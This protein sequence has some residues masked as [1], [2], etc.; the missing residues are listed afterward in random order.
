MQLFAGIF[1]SEAELLV[2]GEIGEVWQVLVDSIDG[3]GDREGVVEGYIAL[4][5]ERGHF[6]GQI[7]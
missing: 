3:W 1:D 6:V 5:L 7:R 4:L 2:L